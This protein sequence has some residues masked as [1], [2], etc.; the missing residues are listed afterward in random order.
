MENV[1]SNDRAKILANLV[2]LDPVQTE[3]GSRPA[4]DNPFG[5]LRTLMVAIKRRSQRNGAIGELAS[6]SNWQLTDI[7]LERHEIP[8]VVDRLM[9]SA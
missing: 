3:L 1:I 4:G 6:L 8:A 5:F 7:G 2:A 9:K